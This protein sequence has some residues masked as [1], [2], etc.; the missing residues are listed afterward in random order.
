MR[1][2]C[3]VLFLCCFAVPGYA[4]TPAPPVG[5]T[6]TS[7]NVAVTGWRLECDPG[8][9]ALACHANDSIVQS[10]NGGLVIRF[11]VAQTADGKTILTMNVP[12]GTSVRTPI[13][14]SVAGGPS[15]SFQFLT[16]S[17]QGCYATG[18]LNSDLLAAMREAKGDLRVVY[19][20]LDN[21]LVPH[22]ITASLSL[23]GFSQVDD[24]L[25]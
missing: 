7:A 16:C 22:T 17:Q 8:K 20:V 3:A 5:G 1:Y 25:K 2:A 11:T 15:Q 6:T 21:N 9:T 10:S 4:A 13:G 18:S 24:R 23:V 12:L 14:V 19:D